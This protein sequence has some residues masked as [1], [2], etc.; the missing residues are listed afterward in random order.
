MRS[1]RRA[2]D[3]VVIYPKDIQNIIGVADRTARHIMQKV[4]KGLGKEKHMYV[5]VGEFCTY[6]GLDE[7]KVREML[8]P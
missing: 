8:L 1:N 3:R 6:M 5:S 4:K 2:F 7:A